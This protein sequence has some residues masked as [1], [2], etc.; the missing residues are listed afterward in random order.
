MTITTE[1][2]SQQYAYTDLPRLMGLMTGDEK[3]GPAATSTLDALWV[4]YDRVLRVAPERVDEPGRDRF[5]L[6]KGHGPMAYYA[7][8]A[9]KGFLPVDWLPDFGSYDSPLGHHPDRV[10]VPGAEIGSGSLGHGLPIAVGTALG[11]RA[12]GL[13]EPRVWVLT[14]DAELDE[15]SN[16]EAIAYAGAAGLERLHTIVIDNSS[17]THALTGGIAARF[18]AAGWATTTVDGH[19]HEALHAAFTA[20][21]EGRPLAVVARVRPKDA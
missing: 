10:L 3:H 8:L 9:A 12:Q 15:G 16:H 17:A 21:H 14:G 18:E 13:G 4:L 19:D 20:P 11:L 7:V 2:G 1:R 6:S 5:L